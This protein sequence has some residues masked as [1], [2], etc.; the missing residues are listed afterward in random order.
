MEKKKMALLILDSEV[1]SFIADLELNIGRLRELSD[2]GYME[3]LTP[4]LIATLEGMIK[5]IKDEC[6]EIVGHDNPP[7][8][9][10]TA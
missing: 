4:R 8:P 3:S 7:G 9:V 2:M 6:G 5:D 1:K 10:D